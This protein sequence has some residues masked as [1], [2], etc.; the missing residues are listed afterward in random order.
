MDGPKDND[1]ISTAWRCL[2]VWPISIVGGAFEQT[3][4]KKGFFCNGTFINH[5]D[6]RG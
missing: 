3:R 4:Q 1:V 2:L 5:V 6:P